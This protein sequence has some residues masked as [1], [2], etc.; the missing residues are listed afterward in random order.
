MISLTKWLKITKYTGFSQTHLDI[1]IILVKNSVS[2]LQ[3][4]II[5]EDNVRENTNKNYKKCQDEFEKNQCI[6]LSLAI[7]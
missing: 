3:N 7:L 5:H 1:F 4:F 2:F 6:W